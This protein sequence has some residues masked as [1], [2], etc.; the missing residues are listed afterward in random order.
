MAGTVTGATLS[1]RAMMRFER[2]KRLPTAGLC[3]AVLGMSVLALAAGR[4]PL[5]AIEIVL[6][7]LSVGLGTLLPVA[8]VSIQNAVAPHQLGTATGTANFF[9]SLGSAFVVAI[10]GAIVLGAS[11]LGSSLRGL[12]NLAAA[13]AQSG[14]D[15]A[16][17]FRWVFAAAT[18]G[19]LLALLFLWRMEE[20]PLR[21]S[22]P[23]A[24]ASSE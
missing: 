20:R 17:V 21:G 11:G 24:K 16:A 23:P 22:A 7:L 4:L 19:F 12:D 6:G 1:G 9:R 14:I 2:Y 15:L 3:I 5:V 18:M 10:F 8:T 13:A